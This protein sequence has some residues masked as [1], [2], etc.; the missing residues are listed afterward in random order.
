M[1]KRKTGSKDDLKVGSRASLKAAPIMLA[2][3][4]FS[5]MAELDGHGCR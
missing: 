4:D 3:M 2:V 1:N 5:F